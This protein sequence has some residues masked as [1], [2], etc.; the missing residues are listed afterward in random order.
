M[1][2]PRS[3]WFALAPLCVLLCLSL[4]CVGGGE[5]S[6]QQEI[7]TVRV[8]YDTWLR[9]IGAT[10]AFGTLGQPWIVA[11][12]NDAEVSGEF[13]VRGWSARPQDIAGVPYDAV[14]YVRL[15]VLPEA[16]H[17]A[18][19]TR[20]R[21]YEI[22]SENRRATVDAETGEW[23]LAL[24]SADMI[25]GSCAIV[26]VTHMETP[27]GIKESNPMAIA[28]KAPEG[29]RTTAGGNWPAPTETIHV[30]CVMAAP[31][32]ETFRD[33]DERRFRYSMDELQAWVRDA[34]RGRVQ[35]VIDQWVIRDEQLPYTDA[36]Y[37]AD[38]NKYLEL[39]AQTKSWLNM[40]Q[41]GRFSIIVVQPGRDPRWY[42][43]DREGRSTH[44][45]SWDNINE[46]GDYPWIGS[47]INM[48][49]IQDYP[50]GALAHELMHGTGMDARG[51][52]QR[53]GL[54]DLYDY[55]G[56]PA[57]YTNLTSDLGLGFDQGDYFLMVNNRSVLPSGYSQQWLGWLEYAD[58]DPGDDSTIDVPYLDGLFGGITTVPRV[59]WT[60]DGRDTYTVLDAR[61]R[62]HGRWDDEVPRTG[63]AVYRIRDYAEGDTWRYMWPRSVNWCDLLERTGDSWVDLDG[64]YSLSLEEGAEYA[65]RVHIRPLLSG[66]DTSPVAAGTALSGAVMSANVDDLPRLDDPDAF[67]S[68]ESSGGVVPDLDLHAYLA[69]GRHI[70][71]N[72][73]TGVYENPVDSALVSG[74]MVMDAEW[75]MLPPDLA[76]T[77]RFEVSSS[78]VQAF[79]EAEPELAEEVGP[80]ELS[81]SVQPTVYDEA[82]NTIAKGE[83]VSGTLTGG[84][85]SD[86]LE[87]D[88]DLDDGAPPAFGGGGGPA[89]PPSW[90]LPA[91]LAGAALLVL[92]GLVLLLKPLRRP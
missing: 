1:T 20:Y 85:S 12:D 84:E 86:A 5:P 24:N 22:T 34:S 79:Q 55:G 33:E 87:L 47:Y 9:N 37:A 53:S 80:I 65:Q 76:A 82:A 67:I 28:V 31:K 59:L 27:T 2:M 81:Y 35:L 29:T 7:Q 57:S 41:S 14:T 6:V 26:A 16:D 63:V 25:S 17:L 64:N 89:A 32:G 23:S 69:D 72:P 54:P 39:I 30:A 40:P 44:S 51:D 90:R 13:E 3:R 45:I 92:I 91:V 75:I 78:D 71:V 46:N 66:G 77:T 68:S 49:V 60:D 11:P 88:I 62:Q 52:T 83:P 61:S 74:D 43:P 58:Y 19:R 15:F 50:V 8:D 70:G 48:P 36:E 38:D 56:A 42:D 18:H 73:Q 21:N 10:G 4:A